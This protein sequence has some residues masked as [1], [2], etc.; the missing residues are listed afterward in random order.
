MRNQ[1]GMAYGL[2]KTTQVKKE[3]DT[4]FRH[5]MGALIL[6]EAAHCDV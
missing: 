3:S 6:D 2:V 4:V 5:A 1:A